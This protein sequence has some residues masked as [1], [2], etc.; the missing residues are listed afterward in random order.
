MSVTLTQVDFNTEDDAFIVDDVYE[1]QHP[2]AAPTATRT[3]MQGSE[4][5]ETVVEKHKD[6]QLRPFVLNT[7]QP[8]TVK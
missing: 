2:P 4:T 7:M 1:E 5:T 3:F 6:R 8:F